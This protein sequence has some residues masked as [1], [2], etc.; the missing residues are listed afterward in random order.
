MLPPFPHFPSPTAK[1][2]E[3]PPDVADDP[4]L[5]SI[6]PAF[7]AFDTPVETFSV[8][9]FPL[10]PESP[11]DKRTSPLSNI[12]WPVAMMNWPL[13]AFELVPVVNKNDPPSFESAETLPASILISPPEPLSPCPTDTTT[14]PETP[15]LPDDSK[16]CPPVLSWATPVFNMIPPED[17]SP[18]LLWMVIAPLSDFELSPLV[19]STAP[20]L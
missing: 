2:I 12:P 16:I 5:T 7:P 4:V 13:A 20:P 11:L 17:K 6:G 18:S 3:P 9:L 14:P 19:K 15:P 1:L 8:P 10:F